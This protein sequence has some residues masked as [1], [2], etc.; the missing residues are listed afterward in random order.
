MRTK[1]NRENAKKW[2]RKD[3]KV[4]EDEIGKRKS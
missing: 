1:R 3:K 2:K 4:E